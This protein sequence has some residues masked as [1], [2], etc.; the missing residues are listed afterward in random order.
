MQ[1][2]YIDTIW[3]VKWNQNNINKYYS[4]AYVHKIRFLSSDFVNL[5]SIDIETM[6]STYQ[7][8]TLMCLSRMGFF[9]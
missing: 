8:L 6:I 3:N 9:P 2:T 1:V 5:I 4:F 7:A